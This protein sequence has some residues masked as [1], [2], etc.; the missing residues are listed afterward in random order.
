MDIQVGLY[1]EV[2]GALRVS[3]FRTEMRLLRSLHIVRR[4]RLGEIG[5]PEPTFAAVDCRL[6]YVNIKDIE[7]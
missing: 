1:S 2:L 3:I 4:T 7:I 5:Q 6:Q